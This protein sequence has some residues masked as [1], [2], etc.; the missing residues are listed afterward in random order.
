[1]NIRSVLEKMIGM[2]ASD[3]HLKAGTA[4]IVRVDGVLY[5]IEERAPAAQELREVCDQLLS[6]EQRQYFSTHHEI[7]FAFGVSGLAR[8]R[9]NIFNQRGA[10]AAVFRV[11]PFEIKSFSQL[12]LPPVVA[13]LCDKPRGLILVTGPTGSGKSTTLAAMIDYIN[14][15]QNGH[16]VTI[17]DPVE[18]THRHQRC[19]VTQREVGSDTKG[20][21]P[22]LKSALRQD[23]D[24]VLI[25]EMRDHETIEAALT[26]AE[27]G[28]LTFGTLHTG[29]A[30]Q[31]VNRIIDVFPSHQQAQVRTQLSFTL[32]AVFCQQLLPLQA[33]RGRCLAAEIMMAT[34]AIRALIRDGK[35]HQIYSAIQT[36]GK[37][38]M[39]TMSQS[40]ADL[41]RSGKVSVDTAEHYIGDTSELRTLVRAA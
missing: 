19:L 38:Q 17:E 36:G 25:G 11:I 1:M 23:P 32:E 40:L 12:N 30:V 34:P 5:T 28:H 3:L 9:A 15:N 16:I 27:T 6:E 18:F 20:F 24:Y 26:L 21:H 29:D 22:A 2:R 8:F 13:K 37:L 33:G 14:K 35:G 41:V 4:P 7:D 39:R 31:T 10:V